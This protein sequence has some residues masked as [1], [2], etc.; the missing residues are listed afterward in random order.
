MQKN[1]SHRFVAS[2]IS[3]KSCSD[4]VSNGKKAGG[5][6]LDVKLSF[7]DVER[8]VKDVPHTEIIASKAQ[9][10]RSEY[11][12]LGQIRGASEVSVLFDVGSNMSSLFDAQDLLK[13]GVNVRIPTTNSKFS[14][15]DFRGLASKGKFTAICDDRRLSSFDVDDILKNKATVIFYTSKA[16]NFSGVE[17]RGFSAKGHIEVIDDGKK[18]SSFDKEDIVKHHGV[19]RA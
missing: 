15:S 5:I 19:V 10:S 14:T 9:L 7:F 3:S 8:I 16:S 2:S 4:L 6:V 18:L 1:E 17:L 13:A 12:R 11:V